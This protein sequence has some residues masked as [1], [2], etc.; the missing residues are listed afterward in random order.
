MGFD[1]ENDSQG[2][3]FLA[4]ANAIFENKEFNKKHLK[5]SLPRKEYRSFLS[6][7]YYNNKK[8]NKLSKSGKKVQDVDDFLSLYPFREQKE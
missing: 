1:K 7:V 2:N 6:K 3:G 4:A 8:I 5:A